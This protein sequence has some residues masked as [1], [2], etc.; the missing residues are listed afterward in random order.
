MSQPCEPTVRHDHTYETN[1]LATIIKTTNSV[2]ILVPP[3]PLSIVVSVI[4][5]FG[6]SVVF[7]APISV[8]PPAVNRQH[9][10]PTSPHVSSLT[11]SEDLL[12]L[13][14]ASPSTV[15]LAPGSPNFYNPAVTVTSLA[16]SPKS[17]ISPLLLIACVPA[18]ESL[19]SHVFNHT[20][21]Y[22]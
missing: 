17:L 15:V 3:A 20:S 19:A 14:L 7:V 21:Q 9:Q 6:P 4:V 2:P 16:V 8:N 22:V 12:V 10:R 18:P 13:V 5:V 1:T 11:P